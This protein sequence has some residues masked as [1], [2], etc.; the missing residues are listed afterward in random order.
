MFSGYNNRQPTRL[1]ARFLPSLDRVWLISRF[2]LHL[3]TDLRW[4]VLVSEDPPVLPKS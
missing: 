4:F 3:P 2:F 1:Y